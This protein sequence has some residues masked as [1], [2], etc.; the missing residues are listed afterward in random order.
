MLNVLEVNILL[1][2]LIMIDNC[3]TVLPGTLL[4]FHDSC[5]GMGRRS[6][7]HSKCDTRRQ[8]IGVYYQESDGP[9]LLETPSR[10]RLGR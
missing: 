4:I 1:L 5:P 3:V 7:E 10:G 9:M 2:V 8:A 6:T